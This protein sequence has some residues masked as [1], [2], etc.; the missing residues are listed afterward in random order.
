MI[1]KTIF[2]RVFIGLIVVVLLGLNFYLLFLRKSIVKFIAE[3]ADLGN[4]RV[5][6]IQEIRAFKSNPQVVN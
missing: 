5:E 3:E 4:K 6:N 2:W 1:N